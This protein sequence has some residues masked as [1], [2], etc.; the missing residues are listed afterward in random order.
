MKGGHH[1]EERETVMKT[2]TTRIMVWMAI[3][4]ALLSA[5]AAMAQQTPSAPDLSTAGPALHSPAPL[6]YEP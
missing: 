3:V 6:V 2:K 4:G 5:A 1:Q